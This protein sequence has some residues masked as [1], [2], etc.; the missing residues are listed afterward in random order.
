MGKD[1]NFYHRIFFA[2]LLGVANS[3]QAFNRILCPAA[4]RP[5]DVLTP[6]NKPLYQGSGKAS[7]L[8]LYSVSGDSE[9]S[10]WKHP[11]TP[12]FQPLHSLIS[13]PICTIYW[14]YRAH[15]PSATWFPEVR[16]APVFSFTQRLKTEGFFCLL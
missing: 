9:S 15:C 16:R 8:V 14:V 11:S 13:L 5:I 4:L 2:L 12:P 10:L 3:V 1:K 6:E 7:C